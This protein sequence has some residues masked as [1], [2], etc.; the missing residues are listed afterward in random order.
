MTRQPTLFDMA[1]HDELEHTTLWARGLQQDLAVAEGR[2]AA[3][4]A[5]NTR[6]QQQ[7][8]SLEEQ[9]STLR[10]LGRAEC[11]FN[12]PF[13]WQRDQADIQGLVKALTH[14][15]AEVHPDR[16]QGSAVA[17]ELTKRVLALREKITRAPHDID[18]HSA[19]DH[20]DCHRR[21]RALRERL[22]PRWRAPQPGA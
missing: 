12:T 18:A 5:E 1:M 14:L 4:K 8:Q 3:L 22:P 21:W 15:A 16:W 19:A 6:L 10:R 17:E 9:V 11:I 13:P 2:I 7:V 20:R